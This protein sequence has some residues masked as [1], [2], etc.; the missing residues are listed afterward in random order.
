LIRIDDEEGFDPI[1]I[2]AGEGG[3]G[4]NSYYADSNTA[5][6]LTVKDIGD[7]KESGA[8]GAEIIKTLVENR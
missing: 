4:D 2:P 8:S 3:S 1:D 6:R 5:Q 7:L